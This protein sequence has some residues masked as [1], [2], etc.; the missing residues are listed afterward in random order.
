MMVNVWLPYM[1]MLSMTL[2]LMQS[3][4]QWVG[5]GKK[6]TLNA[7]AT[8]Q[9]ISIKLASTVTLTLQTCIWLTNVFLFFFSGGRR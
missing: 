6:A 1:L 7:L 5:K 8:K 2:I 4:S 9:A 3:R